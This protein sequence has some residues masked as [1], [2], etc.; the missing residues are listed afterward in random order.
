MTTATH[1]DELPLSNKVVLVTG[2]AR[3]VGAQIALELHDAGACIA[4]HYR[5]ARAEAEALVSALNVQ[6]DGSA[7]AVPA[8]LLEVAQLNRLVDTVVDH[9][10][11]LDGLVNNASSFYPTPLGAISEAHWND[12]IGSNFKAPLFLTQAA[13]PFLQHA[14]GCVVNIIDIHAERPLVNYP[15]YCAAKAGLQGLTRSLAVDLAPLIR[16]NGVAPGPIQWP[17]DQQFDSASRSKIIDQTL[18]KRVGTPRDIARAVRFLMADAPYIT[19]QILAVDG[20]RS[21]NL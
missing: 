1:Y 10:G 8:D 18:L 11:R 9:F 21:I 4:V 7:L 14:E 3:R 12:L 13:S 5:H 17:E 19:G 20:G 6:R 15:L 16:V 2:A